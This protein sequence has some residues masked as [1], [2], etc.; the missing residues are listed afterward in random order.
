MKL[1][2]TV[3]VS[4]V[5]LFAS[6]GIAQAADVQQIQIIETDAVGLPGVKNSYVG[7]TGGIADRKS[8]KGS[9]GAVLGHRLTENVTVEGQYEYRGGNDHLLTGNVL[10][11]QKVSVVEPYVLGGVGY[12]WSDES[13]DSGVYTVGAGIKTDLSETLEGDLRYRFVNSFNG[14]HRDNRMTVGI[15][16][17]F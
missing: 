1:L 15:N 3:L 5:V 14:S 4:S 17:K 12:R 6:F 7:I 10:L 13:K 8:T 16:Y 9:V 2:K 11:G